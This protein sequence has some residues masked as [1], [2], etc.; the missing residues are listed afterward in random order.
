[1]YIW[2]CTIVIYICLGLLLFLA[3][4]FSFVTILGGVLSWLSLLAKSIKMVVA[5]L[6]QQ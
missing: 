4:Y 3:W 5:S 6:A 1:M 2:G